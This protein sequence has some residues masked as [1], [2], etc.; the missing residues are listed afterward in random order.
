MTAVTRK[1]APGRRMQRL[2][3]PDPSP[4]LTASCEAGRPAGSGHHRCATGCVTWG[5]GRPRAPRTRDPA[6][7]PVAA[8][9]GA[10]TAGVLMLQ[11]NLLDGT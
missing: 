10:E 6:Q 2:T 9:A 4:F 1:R 7:D 11:L 5:R 3:I 8:P